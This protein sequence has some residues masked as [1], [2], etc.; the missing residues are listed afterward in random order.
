MD[1]LPVKSPE[2]RAPTIIDFTGAQDKIKSPSGAPRLLSALAPKP[3][4]PSTTT[5]GVTLGVKVA[6]SY[7][8]YGEF[9][10]KSSHLT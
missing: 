10:C 7:P 3:S 9:F 6:E 8:Y 1:P 5:D 4:K 2:R